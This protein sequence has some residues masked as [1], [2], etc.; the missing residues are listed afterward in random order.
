MLVGIVTGN[1]ILLVEYAIPGIRERGMTRNEAV[2]GGLL[3]STLL[4]LLVVPVLFVLLAPL[5]DWTSRKAPDP[6]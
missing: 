4:S 1:S 3:T 2:I 5:D 6:T